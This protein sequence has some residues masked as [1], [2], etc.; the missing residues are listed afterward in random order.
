VASQPNL[1]I[2]VECSHVV[3]E[4]LGGIVVPVLLLES[5]NEAGGVACVRRG[6]AITDLT[7]QKLTA[8]A[9]AAAEEKV[10][11]DLVVGSGVR[12]V[13]HGR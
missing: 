10:V 2:R 4:V 11:V 9:A 3:V 13:E 6:L 12:A 7:P 1:G 8:L 5:S